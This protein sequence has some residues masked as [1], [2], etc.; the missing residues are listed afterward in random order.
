MTYASGLLTIPEP[1]QY[2]VETKLRWRDD[3]QKRTLWLTHD[4][5]GDVRIVYAYD[6]G[7]EDQ[8]LELDEHAWKALCAMLG[9]IQ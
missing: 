2:T 6:E 3:S 4:A 5:D 7:C 8:V 9:E 1:H